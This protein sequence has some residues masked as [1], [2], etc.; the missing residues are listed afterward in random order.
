MRLTPALLA[1]ALVLTITG[2][3]G[4]G[5]GP[6]P[7]APQNASTPA[8]P[9]V[10]STTPSTTSSPKQQPANEGSDSSTDGE[11][12]AAQESESPSS[13]PTDTGEPFDP[14]EFSDRITSAV[15]RAGTVRI[16]MEVAANGEVSARAQGVQDLSRNALDMEVTMGA[17]ELGYRLVNGSYYL[18]QPPK[19]VPVPEN[20]ENP[21]VQQTLQQ[22]QILSIRNLLDAFVTGLD[23]AGVKGQEDVD[24]VATTH[25]TASVDSRTALEELGMDIAPGTPESMH[26]D[27]WVDEDD[28]IRRLVFTQNGTTSTMTATQWGEPIRIEEPTGSQLAAA[29]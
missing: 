21:L 9:S 23:A 15:E 22:I 3:A 24:G 27:V 26:Y 17:Q 12:P 11:A 7:T 28:L 5:A 16:S 19:W 6:G 25:Y 2:C 1:S 13:T 14:D 18:A 4:A 29:P 10:S 8:A 20:S